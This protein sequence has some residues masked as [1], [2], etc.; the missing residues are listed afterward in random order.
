MPGGR[1]PL[2]KEWLKPEKLKQISQWVESGLLREDIAKNMGIHVATL[3]EWQVKFSEFA[4][5][6]KTATFAA[7]E[8]V[9]N[10]LYK[11]T[12]GYWYKEEVAIKVRTDHFRKGVKFTTEK[13]E[14]VALN[15]WHPAETT[16]QIFWLKNRRRDEW[17]DRLPEAPTE[18]QDEIIDEFKK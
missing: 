8:K 4:D 9:E 6:L 1:P 5:I 15:K 18:E 16:A 3:Y 12:I 14:I 11:N 10:A 2:Y 7:D 13:I 17:A